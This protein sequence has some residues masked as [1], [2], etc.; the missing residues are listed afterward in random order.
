MLLEADY[1]L[2]AGS[3]GP[4]A[5]KYGEFPRIY[6]SFVGP[7]QP[8]DICIR[9]QESPGSK[10]I[11]FDMKLKPIAECEKNVNFN[12]SKTYEPSETSTFA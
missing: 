12:I 1:H 5:P 4:P 3:D 7:S 9:P 2:F 8:A 10:D 11:I 6:T